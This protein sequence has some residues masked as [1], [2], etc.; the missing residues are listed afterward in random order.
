MNK[1]FLFILVV[2]FILISN[3]N[4]S[5]ISNLE[6]LNR[7]LVKIQVN[8][9]E[10]ITIDSSGIIEEDYS[11]GTGFYISA[12]GL[13]LTAAHVIKK[14][15]IHTTAA[16]SCYDYNSN[17]NFVPIIVFEDIKNDIAILQNV[18]YTGFG[19]SNTF[20]MNLNSLSNS[21]NKIGSKIYA[22]GYPNELQKTLKVCAFSIGTILSINYNLDGFKKLPERAN[23]SLA[24]CVVIS[25]FSGG[26]VTDFSYK[27]LG[28]ILGSV[29]EKNKRITYFKSLDQVIKILK[30]NGILFVN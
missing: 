13:F 10:G 27:P 26:I 14:R 5:Q 24:D 11:L 3:Y 1:V 28:L 20:Y 23:V 18:T 22:F 29:I 21:I 7:C 2:S 9:T 15:N 8:K 19:K 4:Y 12:D 25:G 16:I 6:S 17:D 30:A